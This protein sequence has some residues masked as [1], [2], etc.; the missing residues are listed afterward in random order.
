MRVDTG[1]LRIVAESRGSVASS[2]AEAR[3]VRAVEDLKLGTDEV[4]LPGAYIRAQRKRL[5]MSLDQ[6]A[7][8]T[9][10][11]RRQ[12]EL[13]EA[14]RYAELPGLVFAKG[15]LRCCA[16]ALDLDPEAV[17][18]LLYER[19]REQLRAKRRETSGIGIHVPPEFGKLG[20]SNRASR[21]LA[22]QL[23]RLPSA[24]ILM[25]LIVGLIVALIVLAAFTLAS[26]QAAETLQ[27]RS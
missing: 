1:R 5:G 17:I 15:F 18:G 19:E 10:I 7:A 3:G 11:P 23:G 14:D 24:Q 2:A 26:G 12:L 25:W 20:R 4:P 13:L 8:L 27:I 9:K 6:L 21:W 22:T 16:R